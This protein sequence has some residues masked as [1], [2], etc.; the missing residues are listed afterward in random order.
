MKYKLEQIRTRTKPETS[1]QTSRQNVS[2]ETDH[3]AA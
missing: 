2:M 1:K 3:L